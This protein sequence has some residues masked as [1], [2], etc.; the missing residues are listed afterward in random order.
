MIIF[1][2]IDDKNVNI[3][4][5]WLHSFFK[6]HKDSILKPVI[7]ITDNVD[8]GRFKHFDVELRLVSCSEGCEGGRGFFED[9]VQNAMTEMLHALDD[10]TERGEERVLYFDADVM[11]QGDVSLL[12]DI[13]LSKDCWLAGRSDFVYGHDEIKM[14]KYAAIDFAY[15]H[16]ITLNENYFNSGALVL[17][18]EGLRNRVKSKGCQTLVEYYETNKG[19]YIFPDQDCLNELADN[20]FN[21]PDTYNAFQDLMLD[22]TLPEC[23]VRRDELAEAKVVHFIGETKPWHWKDFDG[24]L[25]QVPVRR[26]MALVEECKNIVTEEFY[27]KVKANT[28]RLT[29]WLDSVARDISPLIGVRE[30]MKL[31]TQGMPYNTYP[32]ENMMPLCQSPFTFYNPRQE[33]YRPCCSRHAPTFTPEGEWWNS[34]ELRDFRK[35]M[36]QYRTLTDAC[37]KCMALP[38]KGPGQYSFGFEPSHYDHATGHYR[39]DPV[40]VLVFVGNKCDLACV[41]CDSEHS[42]LYA[43]NNPERN[44]PVPEQLV[45]INPMSILTRFDEARTGVLMGGETLMARGIYEL[46]A[47]G[48]E[49]TQMFF[50]IL[51]NGNKD[52]MKNKTFVDHIIPNKHRFN[53]TVSLDGLREHNE[54]IRTGINFDQVVANIRQSLELGLETAVHLTFSKH[55]LDCWP[56]FCRMLND[57]GFFKYPQFLLHAGH[58]DEPLDHHPTLASLDMKGRALKGLEEFTEYKEWN[59]TEHQEGAIEVNFDVVRI[60]CNGNPNNSIRV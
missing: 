42:D 26:Y 44:L 58:V 13:P 14:T 51:T 22:P 4:N 56:D 50:P 37:K 1:T 59:L 23:L 57:E 40:E 27:G 48:L 12:A 7:Y 54:S 11:F 29:D 55:N 33:G 16:R 36:F 53:I 18:L 52:L 60:F 17:H 32:P 25:V 39:K 38:H 28:L 43:R 2:C 6:H 10:L 46:V 9:S 15:N 5:V 45:T 41:T 35:T 24:R 3:A 20:F 30:Y 19:R 47:H 31:I 21:L 49:H 8:P 34:K